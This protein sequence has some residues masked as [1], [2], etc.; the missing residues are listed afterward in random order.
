ADQRIVLDA[1]RSHAVTGA[2]VMLDH[3]GAL[4][5]FFSGGVRPGSRM[6]AGLGPG[7]F[8]GGFFLPFARAAISV[9]H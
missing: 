6:G 1:Q 3:R 9:L 7:R 8:T 2:G 4:R 5:A